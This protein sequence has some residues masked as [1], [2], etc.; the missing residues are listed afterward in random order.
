MIS[1]SDVRLDHFSPHRF[2]SY[3]KIREVQSKAITNY[4]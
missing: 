4:R 3:T 1:Q 2:L